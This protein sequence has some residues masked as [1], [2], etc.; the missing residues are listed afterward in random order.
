MTKPTSKP[1][2]EAPRLLSFEG[3]LAV[4]AAIITAVA[5]MNWFA[6]GL[7]V[8]LAIGLIIHL[9]SRIPWD[10]W[11]RATVALVIIAVFIMLS[12]RPIWDDYHRSHPLTAEKGT[13]L[14]P[15]LRRA[16]DKTVVVP[17]TSEKG[18]EPHPSLRPAPDKSAVERE[19]SEKIFVSVTPDYLMDLFKDGYR[20][21]TD[22]FTV[23]AGNW[24]RVS[25][26]F[27]KP[28]VVGD[29]MVSVTFENDK[30]RRFILLFFDKEWLK[31]L[32]VL[33]PEQTIFAEYQII[34]AS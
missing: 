10:L 31:R 24:I 30:T 9:A 20:S 25:G 3:G 1:E 2:P 23:Y 15:S 29:T 7:F 13:E 26:Q 14:R 16:P 21:G 33:I 5:D 28:E 8:L 27:K 17:E 6:R 12:W 4:L 18:P 32:V 22:S 11:I 19:K 34:H